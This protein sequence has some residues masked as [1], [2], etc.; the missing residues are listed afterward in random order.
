MFPWGDGGGGGAQNTLNRRKSVNVRPILKRGNKIFFVTKNRDIM[1]NL[2][3]HFPRI[4]STILQ[5][6]QNLKNFCKNSMK[7][8][9]SHEKAAGFFEIAYPRNYNSFMLVLHTCS[10]SR[11]QTHFSESKILKERNSLL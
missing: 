7:F 3:I 4:L 9:Q 5:F 8:S 1:E 6:P 10:S 11:Y 2:T